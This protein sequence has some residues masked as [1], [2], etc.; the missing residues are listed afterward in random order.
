MKSGTATRSKLSVVLKIR[1]TNISIPL[2]P[3]NS[4]KVIVPTAPVAQARGSPDTNRMTKAININRLIH[5]IPS[6]TV[7][8]P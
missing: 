2:G 3:N 1:E 8:S 5:S 7:T 4:S 6:V